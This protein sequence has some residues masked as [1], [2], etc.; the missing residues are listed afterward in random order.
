MLI[1]KRGSAPVDVSKLLV[2]HVHMPCVLSPQFEA[3]I[4]KAMFMNT[5]L[6]Q[7]LRRHTKSV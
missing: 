3:V 6:L 2:Y 4:L 7:S 5:T 1:F